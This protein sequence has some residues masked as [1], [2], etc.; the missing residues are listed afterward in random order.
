M[1]TLFSRVCFA[2]AV[3][4]LPGSAAL[5]QQTRD[6]LTRF[7]DSIFKPDDNSQQI[8]APAAS[9]PEP[10]RKPSSRT[11][12]KKTVAAPAPSAPA[13]QPA[14]EPK[15]L[16]PSSP[17]SEETPPSPVL[18]ETKPQ[19]AA[20]SPAPD[21]PAEPPKVKEASA[22]PG[23]P[24]PM[25]VAVVAKAPA[26]PSI[27]ATPAAALDRIN[28]YFN[29]MDQMTASFVQKNP[30]GQQAEG[31]L[32]VKRPGI[33]H[34]AYGPPSTLEVVSDGRNVAIRDRRLGTND[35]Y[36]IGQT[37]LKFLLQEDVDLA[38]DGMVRDVQVGHD[39]E[40]T[41]RFDDRKTLGGTSRIT[42]RF[43]ARANALKQWTI[44]DGQGYE[45]SVTLS[46]LV[47]V[48]RKDTEAVE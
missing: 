40:V 3:M 21:T 19:K 36:P 30:N 48:P 18:P 11:P 41:V 2:V 5:A 27:P 35:V 10:V 45:T 28:A 44:I 6:P 22:I 9:A 43:D 25:P 31:T 26:P 46:N 17:V 1:R 38:R 16:P 24:P 7:L 37:P 33:L 14:A 20:E 13:P 32:A 15:A 12:R 34:F 47:M 4:L 42:L 29:G 23:A 39:G 8:E